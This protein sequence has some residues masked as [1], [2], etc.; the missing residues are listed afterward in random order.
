MIISTSHFLHCQQ[1]WCYFRIVHIA[2]EGE[3]EEEKEEE[4]EGER[5]G[6]E[7]GREE[8]KE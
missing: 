8:E 2:G 7:R 6:R 5:R 3:G 1:K 4:R